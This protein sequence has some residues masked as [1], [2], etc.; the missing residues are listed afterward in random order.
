MQALDQRFL[1]CLRRKGLA[2]L[3]QSW[4]FQAQICLESVGTWML[5]CFPVVTTAH[6]HSPIARGSSCITSVQGGRSLQAAPNGGFLTDNAGE[7]GKKER[8]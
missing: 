2:I 1:G 7:E 5:P 3:H 8:R 6:S 4:P